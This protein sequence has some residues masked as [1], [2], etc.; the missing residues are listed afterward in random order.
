M[1]KEIIEKINEKLITLGNKIPKYNQV[2]ILA[3]GAGSGKGFI[4]DNL[5]GIEG[6]SIDVDRLKELS[7]K[8]NALKDLIKEKTGKD[9]SKL[10]LK[11]PDDVTIL[12]EIISSLNLDKKFRKLLYKGISGENKPNL[13]FDVTMKEISKLNNISQEVQELGYRK[14]DI[15]IVWVVNDYQTAL[16]QNAE[17]SRTIKKDILINT[18]ELVSYTMSRILKGKINI[19]KYM[20]GD[21]WLVFNKKY[22]DSILDISDKG[23]KY[24]KDVFYVKIKEQGKPLKALNEIEKEVIDKIKEYVPNPEIW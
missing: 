12:H 17:R 9:I 19:Q 22:V 10:N 23:G 20:N 2:V 16:Q 15:H 1:L 24:I 4:K 13:I 3:G 18:H 14:E 21:F 7:L 8:S 11:N 5:L 6:K